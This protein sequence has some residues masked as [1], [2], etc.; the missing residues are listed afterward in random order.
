MPDHPFFRAK[1][2]RGAGGH[3]ITIIF[4]LIEV[5]IL[6]HADNDAPSRAEARAIAYAFKGVS[7][8]AE[9]LRF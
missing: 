3:E 5:V 2:A 6:H 7:T 9:H 4:A 1:F 8:I